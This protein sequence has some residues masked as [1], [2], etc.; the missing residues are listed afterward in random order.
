M[1]WHTRPD[2]VT[3]W[4]I[5]SDSLQ[6]AVHLLT[7]LYVINVHEVVSTDVNDDKDW[8]ETFCFFKCSFEVLLIETCIWTCV[9]FDVLQFKIGVAQLFGS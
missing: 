3:P 7:E 8:T 6:Q 5:V 2:N 1:K 4:M 9:P